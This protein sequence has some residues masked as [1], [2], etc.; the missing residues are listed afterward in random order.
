MCNVWTGWLRLV[1][2]VRVACVSVMCVCVTSL[3]L[4][5]RTFTQRLL[6]KTRTNCYY[7]LAQKNPAVNDFESE[8]CHGFLHGS[9]ATCVRCGGMLFTVIGRWMSETCISWS[10]N[11]GEWTPCTTTTVTRPR[12]TCYKRVLRSR[13][14]DCTLSIKTDYDDRVI[15]EQFIM[16][17]HVLL[18][19]AVLGFVSS[20]LSQEIGLEER[21]RNYPFCI[22]CRDVKRLTRPITEVW[23]C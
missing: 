19:F 12:P 6:H 9:V 1:C 7:T 13:R 10:L 21:L 3:T 5:C 18:P 14:H 17:I 20:V 4:G 2:D 11:T 23:E 16:F 15:L 8:R 22:E